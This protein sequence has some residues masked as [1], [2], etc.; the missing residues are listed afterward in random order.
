MTSASPRCGDTTGLH[1]FFGLGSGVGLYIVEPEDGLMEQIIPASEDLRPINV[2]LSYDGEKL[3]VVMSD[4]ELRMYDAHDLDLLASARD[5]LSTPVETGFWGRPHIA[6]APGAIFITDSVGGE[7]M[8]LDTHDLE[9]VDHWDVDG[10]PTKIAFVGILGEPEHHEDEGHMEEGEEH[11]HE[12]EEEHGHDEEEDEHGHDHAHGE[13]DPHFWFDPLR[14]QQAV[15]LIA[16]ELSALDP[17]GQGYFLANAESYNHELD[18]LHHWIEDQVA[19]VPEGHRVL[20]TSHDAFQY[21]A[22]RYGF[23]VVGTVFPLS[24]EAEPSAKELIELVEAI[25]REGVPAVFSERA[26]SDRLA[27]RVAEETGVTLI[28]ALYAGSLGQPGEE[29]GTYLDFMRFNVTTIADA[30]Q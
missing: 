9:V 26:H 14:V 30:L 16:V 6:T 24:T 18:D 19:R 21:F 20:V 3:L 27:R 2:A 1:H 8:Q 5:F 23:E 7:V 22:Q 15:N 4:G 28:G 10:N 29:A 17:D 25:E 11:G 13:L 12:E